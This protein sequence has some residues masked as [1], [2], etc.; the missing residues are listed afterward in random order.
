M[1]SF[2]AQLST[3]KRRIFAA[4]MLPFW[5]LAGCSASLQ[6]GPSRAVTQPEISSFLRS[7]YSPEAL[8]A[9][10]SASG[11]QKEQLRNSIVLSAMG[12]M[13]VEYTKFEQNLTRERQRVPFL[14]SATSIALSGT[15]TLIANATTKSI[16]AAVDTG[17]KGT[18]EAYDKNILASQTIAFLQTQ[19]RTN[20][21]NVRSRIIAQL[22]E[23]I[24]TYP[25]E[26]AFGDLEDYYS[27]GTITAGLIG[28]SEAT[29]KKLADSEDKKITSVHQFG[30]N[31]ATT[32]IR[33]AL[34]SGGD[35]ALQDL[36]AWLSQQK[37]QAPVVIF[38]NSSEYAAKRDAYAKTL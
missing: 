11:F 13:D 24:E 2:T 36:Q 17:L 30:T 25:L 23:P 4:A 19:M 15:G 3:Q 10:Q 35:K 29:T 16:L 8:N 18:K 32:K 1:F 22:A 6:G 21:N 37:I 34:E 28:I 20:R 26:L 14:A 9:Y 7:G 31:D 12:A 5:T 27:A 38:L 33:A